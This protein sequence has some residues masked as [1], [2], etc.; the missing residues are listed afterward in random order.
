MASAQPPTSHVNFWAIRVGSSCPRAAT[1]SCSCCR[2]RDTHSR[3][4]DTCV[5]SPVCGPQLVPTFL[6]AVS[7]A[8]V[9]SH[10]CPCM[11]G[12]CRREQ[13]QAHPDVISGRTILSLCGVGTQPKG[14]GELQPAQGGVTARGRGRQE[15]R[16][17][18]PT[19]TCVSRGSG[20]S[21]SPRMW[22]RGERGALWAGDRPKEALRISWARRALSSL[23]WAGGAPSSLGR[24]RDSA[25]STPYLARGRENPTPAPSICPAA[26]RDVSGDP[27]ATL[28][29]PG[30]P[31]PPPSAPPSP[32]SLPYPLP[33]PA[34]VCTPSP[35]GHVPSSRPPGWH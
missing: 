8:A 5:C 33:S 23:S 3:V 6:G 22:H 16:E 7:W 2:P 13:A 21:W 30:P 34:C 31:P 19:A 10:R 35:G 29:P 9:S 11:D 1:V 25:R 32:W 27:T 4:G 26:P 28:L 12:H 17:R 14:P 15:A 24:K 18:K 20:S